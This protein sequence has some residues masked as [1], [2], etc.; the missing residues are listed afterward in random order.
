MPE[1]IAQN[2]DVSYVHKF[3][4]LAAQYH[5]NKASFSRKFTLNGKRGFQISNKS[6]QQMQKIHRNAYNIVLFTN[7]GYFTWFEAV[8]LVQKLTVQ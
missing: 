8:N 4:N 5:V 7:Y 2:F 1:F 3:P 6:Y